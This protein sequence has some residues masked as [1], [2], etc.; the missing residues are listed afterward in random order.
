MRKI[1]KRI[2]ALMLSG[3]MVASLTACGGNGSNNNAGTTTEA[4]V[5]TEVT[6][7]APVAASQNL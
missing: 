3:A 4:P 1:S 2:F 5:A 7:E 6:T